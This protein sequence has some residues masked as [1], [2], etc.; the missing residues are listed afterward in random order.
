MFAACLNGDRCLAVQFAPTHPT[1]LDC[2]KNGLN[3]NVVHQL[4]VIEA[5]WE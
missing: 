5:L 1:S 4:A 2:G 3:G